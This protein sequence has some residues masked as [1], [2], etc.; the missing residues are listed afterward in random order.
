MLAL[1][2]LWNSVITVIDMHAFSLSLLLGTHRIQSGEI[3]RIIL[4]SLFKPHI[5]F[6]MA[7]EGGIFL[8]LVCQ[9]TFNNCFVSILKVGPLKKRG[10]FA[11]CRTV[12]KNALQL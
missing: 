8:F 3:K 12:I 2:I 4:S 6:S 5:L 9:L 11:A 10:Q 1:E 7:G